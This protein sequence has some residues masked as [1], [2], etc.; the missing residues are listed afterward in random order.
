MI[1]SSACTEASP[2]PC[3]PWTR[4]RG[5]TKSQGCL[6]TGPWVTCSSLT[7]KIQQ[8]G[9][10][11]PVGLATC[12]AVSWWPSSM[13]PMAL[14]W[15]ALCSPAGDGR[16]QVVLQWNC[17]HGGVVTQLLL[18]LWECS[19]HLR[20]GWITPERFHHLRGH[21]PRDAGIPSKKPMAGYFLWSF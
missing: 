14:T 20:A 19:D 17:A 8:A 13:Q 1:R 2:H 15:P 3:R 12:L 10:R 9:M 7:M 18:L 16:W 5:L 6:M 21:S 11:A 4:P